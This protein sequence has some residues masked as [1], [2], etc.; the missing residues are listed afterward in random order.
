MRILLLDNSHLPRVGG[1]E[2]VVHHLATQ[3]QKLGH[4]VRVA[5][6]GSFR[7]YRNL[8]FGYPVQRFSNI[9]LVSKDFEWR[10]RLQW[11]TR[12]EPFD[13]VHAH[14][15]HPTGYH[16]AK[17]FERR[18]KK[19]PMIIT[20]HGADIHK[21]PE[22][23]FGKRLD[24]DLDKK[25]RWALENCN[26]ATAISHS[27]RESLLDAGVP[28]ERIVSIPN[29]VDSDRL[30]IPANFDARDYLKL[31]KDSPYFLSVGNYHPRKG[32]KTL[33]E[34]I[35][36]CKD[37]SICAVI[38]GRASQDFVD[39]VKSGPNRDRIIFVGLLDYPVPGVSQGPDVLAS[40]LQQSTGYISASMGE[41]TEGL[42]LALLEAMAT[43][44][45]I[46]ATSVSGNKDVIKD[47]ENGILVQPEKPNEMAL[48]M[49]LLAGD[50]QR[51]KVIGD[52]A[53]ATVTNFTWRAVARQ[54]AELMQRS[55]Y[56]SSAGKKMP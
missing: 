45:A 33:V 24:P 40:L 25:I 34:A 37:K 43:G 16:A 27:V 8:D 20:P 14:T 55:I 38:V 36:R 49:D 39:F 56:E 53:R 50:S 31:K 44:S 13:V 51:R 32:H 12:N 18:G 48:A 46:I 3:Y 11:I 29:G 17:H 35:Q 19:L 21:V 4:N 28:D 15:T 42:S 9:P 54:Y 2:I 7:K 6:P 26:Y 10:L 41:G 47:G 52:R 5:G 30:S 22:V 23:N 1:K